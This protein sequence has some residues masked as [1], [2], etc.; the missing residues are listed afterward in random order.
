MGG[1]EEVVARSVHESIATQS[2][3]LEA[4]RKKNRVLEKRRFEE[5]QIRQGIIRIRVNDIFVG[6]IQI[7][8]QN[9]LT[10]VQNRI[11][12]WLQEHES[13]L[14]KEFPYGVDLCIAGDVIQ[15]T[16]QIFEAKPGEISIVPKPQ[17]QLEKSENDADGDNDGEEGDNVG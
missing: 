14:A 2:K 7:S 1:A 15:N 16:D 6:P 11:S 9:D 8:S 12:E 10:E 5:L 17:P 4:H 3:A 13:H